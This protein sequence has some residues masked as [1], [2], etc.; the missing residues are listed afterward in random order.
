MGWPVN[1][2]ASAFNWQCRIVLRLVYGIWQ[3]IKQC[4]KMVFVTRIAQTFGPYVYFEG[5]SS[6]NFTYAAR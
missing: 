3:I 5:L 4:L 2:W 1:R 6:A